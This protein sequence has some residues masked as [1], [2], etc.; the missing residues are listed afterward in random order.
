MK[1]LNRRAIL[2]GGATAISL[3]FLDAMVPIGR[4]A[5]SVIQTAQPKRLLCI[6][7][8]LG[9]YPPAF[10]PQKS[11]TDYV[12]PTLLKP[13]DHL[14][15]HFT[16]FS[17]LDHPGVGKGHPATVNYLTG[18]ARPDKRRQMS[19]DQVAARAVGGETRFSSLQLESRNGNQKGRFLSWAEG[20]V[21]LPFL[22]DPR[23]VFDKLFGENQTSPV[24]RRKSLRN[25]ESVLDHVLEDARRLKLQLGAQDNSQLDQYLSA[26]R[27][28]EREI[29]RAERFIDQPVSS[30][31]RKLNIPNAGTPLSIT[32]S[33][34]LMLQ[35][36]ALAFQADLT[37]VVT[38]RVPGENHAVSHHGKKQAKVNAYVSLQKGYIQ[39]FADFL[40]YM[41]ETDNVET[42]LLNQSMV[43]LGS[44]MGNSS[45]HS[46]RN[47]P[48]LLAGGG[49]RHGRHISFEGSNKQPLSNLF[50]TLLQ[51]M[52]LET[53]R[54]SSSRSSMNS[55]L[56]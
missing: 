43:L 20:G 13:V 39:Q 45:N 24:Q 35:L 16:V 53:D 18:V 4:A 27:D 15:K 29:E 50:V 51:Q 21:P 9:F 6:G 17:G 10:F 25:A 44:G 28:V 52:G 2:R 23:I 46:T 5:E 38:L 37:R 48:L 54:F 47:L 36:T 49:L 1:P 34:R 42:S 7:V 3:P 56:T 32:Q 12:A 22:S 31:A 14:R 11:G 41:N 8:H 26:I 40:K 55:L 33:T 30:L 19:M